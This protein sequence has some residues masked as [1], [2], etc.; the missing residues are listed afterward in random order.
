VITYGTRGLDDHRPVDAD[1]VFD[2]GSITKVFTSIL[3]ADL[4]QRG[5]LA[6]DDPVVRY[7][8]GLQVP[9]RNGRTITLADLAT[10]TSGLPLRPTNLVSTDPE[11]RYAGYTHKHLTEFL[12]HYVL[13]RD[14][15]P[16]A[17]GQTLSFAVRRDRM[18]VSGE[19]ADPSFAP[20][21]LGGRV[22]ELEY[23]GIYM[24]VSVATDDPATPGCVV[25]VEENTFFRD[26][27][28]V[29]QRVRCHWAFGEAHGLA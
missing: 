26:P 25:Y 27:V 24:K 3:L 21:T 15:A 16:V 9:E 6:I 23:Q 19:P 14:A 29:G 1:T 20:N 22:R 11:N 28:S 4:A 18:G 10:H 12:A 13:P 17:Q 2:V 5:K 7:L 8:P